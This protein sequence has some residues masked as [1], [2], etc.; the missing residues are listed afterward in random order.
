MRMNTFFITWAVVT[1]VLLFSGAPMLIAAAVG[2]L[3]GLLLASLF[4]GRKAEKAPT[5]LFYAHGEA[6]LTATYA[7]NNIAL[8]LPNRRLWLRD[9]SGQALIVHLDHV[10]AWEHTWTNTTNTYGTVGRIKNEMTFRLRQLDRPTVRIRFSRHS[11]MFNGNANHAEAEA[12]QA[13]LTTLIN[14]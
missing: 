7:S 10:A 14:G 2:A 5:G 9:T 11:D 4:G 3:A 1:V 13:R 8:D 12:W 6:P